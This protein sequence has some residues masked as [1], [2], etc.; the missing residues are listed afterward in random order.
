MLGEVDVKTAY[1]R[2]RGSVA[3]RISSC[4]FENHLLAPPGG[5]LMVLISAKTGIPEAIL[6]DNGYLSNVR[7]GAAGALAARYL[8]RAEVDTVGVIGSGIQ[9]RFQM[10][11]LKLVRNYRKLMVYGVL[12]EEVD[13][14]VT[15]MS[16]LLGVEIVKAKDAESVVGASDIVVTTTS[17]K[18]P[19]L[20]AEWLHAGLHITAVGSD[21]GRKQELCADLLGRADLLACDRKSQC[22]QLGELHHALEGDS[23]PED[24]KIVELGELI[25]GRK[26]GRSNEKQVTVC[27]LTGTGVEDTVIAWLAYR[28]ALERGLGLRIRA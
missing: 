18:E 23:V 5:G 22:L 28:K 3:V 14:F 2:G 1:V 13:E 10:Y 19:Y 4:F 12:P 26:L 16:P 8:A 7:T 6:V 24:E 9:A 21:A 11:A 17:S 27:D 25:S 15:E 20:R